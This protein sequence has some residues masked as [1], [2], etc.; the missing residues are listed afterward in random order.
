MAKKQDKTASRVKPP[1]FDARA[2]LSALMCAELAPE[3]SERAA[4]LLDKIM[5]T[6]V[7]ELNAE[8][9][10]RLSI[11]LSLSEDLGIFDQVAGAVYPDDDA[12][13]LTLLSLR[14]KRRRGEIS[15]E[16]ETA[17]QLLREFKKLKNPNT[18]YSRGLFSYGNIAKNVLEKKDIEAMSSGLS[19]LGNRAGLAGGSTMIHAYKM[20][21]GALLS[22]QSSYFHT[23]ETLGGIRPD[24]LAAQFGYIPEKRVSKSGREI[25]LPT[26]IV[27]PAELYRQITGRN[28]ISGKELAEQSEMLGYLQRQ[29]IWRQINDNM[30]IGEPMIAQIKPIIMREYDDIGNER[31]SLAY[32][33]TLSIDFVLETME[34]EGKEI[35]KD[36][37][38][39]DTRKVVSLTG[40]KLFNA[41]LDY[42]IFHSN[43]KGT[44]KVKKEALK[45]QLVEQCPEYKKNPKRYQA[46]FTKAIEEIINTGICKIK[47]EQEESGSVVF[48]YTKRRRKTSGN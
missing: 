23:T 44:H 27:T 47:A 16:A 18:I 15:N 42:I 10:R 48:T 30:I 7:T 33:I 38:T 25:T 29:L 13:N 26:I 28:N 31:K 43:G 3:L 24:F 12:A 20:G 1:E 9:I 2:A 45:A 4:A 39:I 37:I 17:K 14:E 32:L 40:G 5:N 36:Y 11:Q 41:L 35:P 19:L 8:Q 22:E 34:R 46:D 6:R 21:L